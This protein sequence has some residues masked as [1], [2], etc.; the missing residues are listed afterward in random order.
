MYRAK[1][2]PPI[3]GLKV[4][5]LRKRG[6]SNEWKD[7]RK[8]DTG[9]NILV[10]GGNGHYAGRITAHLA[11]LHDVTV[12]DLNAEPCGF[13]CQQLVGDILHREDIENASN[14]M[15]AIVAFFVGDAALSTM[16]MA[17]VMT[18]AEQGSTK[19]VVYT[20]SGGLPFPGNTYNSETPLFPM[21]EFSAEF[22]RDYFPITEDAGMF[23]GEEVSGY[24]LHKWLCEK[25]GRR[26]AARGKVKFTAI[27]PG[28]LMHDDMT[29]RPGGETTRHYDP[30]FMLMTGQVRMCDCARMY[31]LALRNPPAEFEAYHCSN[32]TPYNNLS[33]DKA[34]RELGYTCIDQQPYIDLYAKMDWEGA[35]N[36]LV[37][38]GFPADMLRERHGFRNC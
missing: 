32:D 22:W 36:V 13:P 14:G 3:S 9:M 23:P 5:A 12:F 35:F 19:H 18:A 4:R 38:K 29:N 2:H 20:S 31:D 37:D 26:F 1:R 10:I 34:K 33:V 11:G 24:F 6:N 27:R 17:N 21:E 15:D 30:F 25:I 7:R 8:K 28:L 16:G